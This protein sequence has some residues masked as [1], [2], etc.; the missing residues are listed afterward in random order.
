MT[1]R[2]V[3]KDGASTITMSSTGIVRDDPVV[4]SEIMALLRQPT[5]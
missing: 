4:R 1:M 5:R 3:R 2:G